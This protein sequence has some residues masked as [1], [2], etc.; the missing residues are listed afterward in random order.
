MASIS[1]KEENTFILRNDAFGRDI[2]NLRDFKKANS[3]LK[4]LSSYDK[5]LLFIKP[6]AFFIS[7]INPTYDLYWYVTCLRKN[8]QPT[9]SINNTESFLKGQKYP[10][11]NGLSYPANIDM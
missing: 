8:K 10:I 11:T 2:Q 9:I 4:G 5:F 6:R 3:Q 1:E 7:K